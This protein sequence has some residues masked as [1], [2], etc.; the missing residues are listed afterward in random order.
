MRVIRI[1]AKYDFSISYNSTKLLLFSAFSH[2]RRFDDD[3]LLFLSFR[4][5]S[6]VAHSLYRFF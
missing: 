6:E 5:G 1:N 4:Q 3:A 2:V